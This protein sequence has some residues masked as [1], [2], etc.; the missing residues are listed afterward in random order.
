MNAKFLFAM[1][2]GTLLFA[3]ATSAAAQELTPN[4]PK[5]SF[6][7]K[8][9]RPTNTGIGGDT[10]EA[11]AI[12]ADGNAWIGSYDPGW[13]EGGLAKFIYSQ[14]RWE[15]I[16]NVDYPEIGHPEVTG[17]TRISDIDQ[18]AQGRFW[19]ATARGALFLDPAKGGKSLRRFG[20]D[21]SPIPGGWNKG[22]EVAP[23]GTVWF[24][25]YSTYWG[26]GGLSQFNP[27]TNQW[28]VFPDYGGGPLAIQPKPGGGYY[29]WTEVNEVVR[30]DSTTNAFTVFGKQNGNPAFV[31]G[32]NLTDSAGNTWMFKW[33][34]VSQNLFALD[35]R[36]PNGTWANVPEF[37]MGITISQLRALG[38][39]QLLLADGGAGAWKF[40]GTSWEYFGEWRQSTGTED[41]NIDASG[42]IWVCAIGGAAR[43]DAGTGQWQR[44]RIT[45]TSQF[46]NFNNDLAL[47]PN[48][49][50]YATA[51]AA[52][53]YGGMVKFDGQ[54]W[55]GF[56]NFS[57]G[58]GGEWPFD[59]DNSQ[60]LYYRPSNGQLIVNP[61]FHFTHSFDGEN[62]TDLNM[63]YDVSRAYVEDSQ[64]RLWASN[65]G[66]VGYTA[67]GLNWTQIEGLGASEL[68]KD[69][70][71]PGTIW[72]NRGDLIYKTNGTTTVTYTAASFPQL[73]PLTEP[74]LA[75]ATVVADGT[76]WFAY[77]AS[78]PAHTSG[79]VHYNPTTGA[80]KV[81]GPA[82]G[83]KFPG[84]AIFILGN[85]P[86]GKMW[87]Y[88][89][90]DNFFDP[91]RGMG[92]F[93]G[94]NSGYFEA[95]PNGEFVWDGLAHASIYDFEVQP[96]AKGYNIWLSTASRGLSV[97]KVNST[98]K[99]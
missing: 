25:A 13:E 38:P 91:H 88:F 53:G 99:R 43:R 44:Y 4:L 30:F 8:Y 28:R 10:C 5:G 19:M 73:N 95:P 67:N 63:P 20:A 39:N 52:A 75:G 40:N 90:D 41:I 80:T 2:S 7:W 55:T 32:K 93:D 87:F 65:D 98:V 82:Q 18:D 24:S 11:I 15:N 14:N 21:N 89:D 97:L 72:A 45:N 62:W 9:Y 56:S 36:R 34:D 81:F 33:T 74:H 3:L 27:A 96:T 37:P 47:G 86:D 94:K 35:L 42:N 59:T 58:I 83:F 60:S 26:D 79:F 68:M 29:V 69:P 54:R 17:T 12:G 6:G 84:S 92:W 48:G 66:Y 85:S 22:V 31:Y 57:Y 1:G 64:S 23:D 77:N 16:S 49:T 70:I 71:R 50:V 61:M 76:V 51:N 78:L 46:D